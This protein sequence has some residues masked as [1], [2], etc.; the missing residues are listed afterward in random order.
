MGCEG[1]ITIVPETGTTGTGHSRS[2]AR[3][4]GFVA[5]VARGRRNMWIMWIMV[6]KLNSEL[7]LW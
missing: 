6:A 5:M 2:L 1:G 4:L 3:A 7:L